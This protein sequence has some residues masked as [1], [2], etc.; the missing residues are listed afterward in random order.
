MVSGKRSSVFGAWHEG[1]R[2]PAQEG[3]WQSLSRRSAPA[4]ALIVDDHPLFRRGARDLMEASGSFQVV[5]EAGSGSEG[6]DLALELGPDL[7]VLD[8]RLPDLDGPAALIRMR[9]AGV[10]ARVAIV[11]VS[12]D[13]EDL[14]TA[15][16]A[17]ADGYLLKS[18]APDCLLAQLRRI[19]AGHTVLGDGLGES[20]A[21]AIRTDR[22]CEALDRV[23]LTDR[24]REILEQIALG[25]SNK[26]IARQLGIADS[27]VKVHVKHL[28]KKLSLNSRVEAALWCIQQGRH[29]DSAAARSGTGVPQRAKPVEPPRVPM[30]E[31][32][33]RRQG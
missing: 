9:E 2:S 32:Q 1:S 19:A 11:T 18:T 5:G 28:L 24:E 10:Q 25:L 27:T 31:H 23:G 21:Q 26:E 33:D 16:R 3:G 15:L 8:L 30:A 4:R 17:G 7:V 12:D 14:T 22:R 29:R 20:L 13:P 6:L